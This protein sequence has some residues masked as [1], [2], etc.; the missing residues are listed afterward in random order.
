MLTW[1]PQQRIVGFR[2]TYRQYPQDAFHADPGHVLPL[3]A[4]KAV[5]KPRYIMN[6]RA[7]GLEDY[8]GHQNVTGLLVLKDGQ[9][10]IER[11]THGNTQSTLWTSRSVA[12]SIVSVLV[13]IAVHEGFIRSVDDQVTQYLPELEG[14]AWEGVS[15]RN[16][17]QHTSGVRWNENYA[18]TNSDFAQLNRCEAQQGAF[19]C[20]LQLVRSV[21]R[22]PGVSPGELWSYNTGGAWL[23]GRVLERA[24]RMTVARYLESRLWRRVGMEADGIW[25]ALV[26]GRVDMGGHGFNATLRDW[27]RFGWFVA[28]G[29]RLPGGQALLPSDWMRQSTNWTRARGSVTPTTP[30]GQYGYQWWHLGAPQGSTDGVKVTAAQTIWAL[31]IYGQA[32][33]INPTSGVVMVQWSAHRDADGPDSLYDEQLVF[34]SAVEQALSGGL[35][36]E[37][38]RSLGR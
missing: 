16:L 26:P 28:S 29:G 38:D 25:E 1:T 27:G 14:T 33:A 21:Q 30:E 4:Y 7:C 10:V 13:G 24:T 5:P 2:N 11:Y 23:V 6:G 36:L 32:L 3:P 31:G 37:Q 9:I 22:Q 19:D 34:F 12:K 20:V 18:D 35:A 15:L 8:I 17:L